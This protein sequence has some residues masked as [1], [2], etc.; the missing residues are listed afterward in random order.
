M[1]FGESSNRD[2]KMPFLNPTTK[3]RCVVYETPYMAI[4]KL[5][6]PSLYN[7]F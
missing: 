6:F 5:V 2:E 7:L 4:M 1:A 3:Y